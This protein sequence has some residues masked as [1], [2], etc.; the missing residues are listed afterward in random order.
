[1]IEFKNVSKVYPNGAVALNNV[2]IKIDKGEFVFIV[3]SSGAGKSTFLKLIMCEELP[4]TGDI[5]FNGRNLSKIRRKDVPYIRRNMGIV[6]QDFRL[7]DHMTV[8]DNIAFAMHVVGANSKEIKMRVPYICGLVGLEK[9]MNCR[10]YE[11]SGGE[12]QRVGLAR[13]LVNNPQMIIADEPTGNVD[14]DLSFEIVDLLNEINRRGTT[15]LMVTH[16]HDLVQHF[17]KRVIE[18]SGGAVVADT[19]VKNTQQPHVKTT[20]SPESRTMPEAV[21]S[22]VVTSESVASAASLDDT[23]ASAYDGQRTDDE[24]QSV[25][26]LDTD[27]RELLEKYS[28][29]EAQ[30]DIMQDTDYEEEVLDVADVTSKEMTEDMQEYVVHIETAFPSS[31]DIEHSTNEKDTQGK[32]TAENIVAEEQSMHDLDALEQLEMALKD[33]AKE[34][35]DDKEVVKE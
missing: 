20:M 35:H 3:G 33:E 1:M 24:E 7:I 14:P 9:K 11:L 16:E 25:N 18:I 27:Y 26:S 30:S 13:A 31:G 15:V 2:N 10:P 34:T 5:I 32:S 28:E 21:D 19:N 8:Y 4:D 23:L 22:Q 17:H 6:F 29:Y 12:Q